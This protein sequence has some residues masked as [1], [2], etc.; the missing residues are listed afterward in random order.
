MEASEQRLSL[1]ENNRLAQ[2]RVERLFSQTVVSQG[3][4][5]LLAIIVAASF[6]DDTAPVVVAGWLLVMSFTVMLR[7]G[8]AYRY[9]HGGLGFRSAAWWEQAHAWS[10]LASGVA[11]GAAGV[12][13]FNH[14][15][16]THQVML[17]VI[18]GG[19]SS[20]AVPLMAVSLR[21]VAS[22]VVPAI[23]PGAIMLITQGDPDSRGL[24]MAAFVYIGT[25]LA[26]ARNF[27]RAFLQ[28]MYLE[29][30]NERLVREAQGR[31]RA[32]ER[33]Q[34]QILM[35]QEVA[36]SLFH[37]LQPRQALDA[38]NIAY[39]ISSHSVFNGDLLLAATRP[40]GR[41]HFLLGDFT[42]HGLA[43]SLGTLPVIDIFTS[44]TAKGFSICDIAAEINRKLHLQLP[45]NIFFAAC[46]ADLD[47]QG[48]QLSVWNGG[49][50]S[51]Y[52][53][54]AEDGTIKQQLES[55]H[56]PL[57]I[58]PEEAFD[59]RPELVQVKEGDQL[60]MA[61]DGVIEQ[62]NAE[63]EAFGEARLEEV[64]NRVHAIDAL[65][66]AIRDALDEFCQ[67]I[68]QTDDLTY[69]A[70]VLDS[71]AMHQAAREQ[72][73]QRQSGRAGN[74]RLMLELEGRTLRGVDPV[75]LVIHLIQELNH[76]EVDA[77]EFELVVG[78]LYKNAL[79]H[80]VL[81]LD[82]SL[83]D[84][85]EGFLR[86]YDE[87]QNRLESLEEGEVRIEVNHRVLEGG[88]GQ[89][90]LQVCD[91]GKG[92]DHRSLDRKLA[93]NDGVHGRGVALAR[94]LCEDVHFEGD[95]NQV[96]ACYRWRAVGD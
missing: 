76:R 67:G 86:Y 55:R 81:E 5:L 53:L 10:A 39:H 30:S 74:W 22:F 6:S 9:E 83:K 46:L 18:L 54:R 66:E 84:S 79:D 51:V 38:P 63:G 64:L 15:E 31:A 49:L 8:L 92:F 13:F 28:N 87:R 7:M 25:L 56:P 60:F 95:G 96:Y 62:I 34:E 65:K 78:E 40:D 35:E 80:G 90:R 37:A 89:L 43:A 94:E 3:A 17:L 36:L 47:P 2:M 12:V 11:W 21:S 93:S 73:Q 33:A 45:P 72:P 82:S 50:P 19:V 85:P 69:L 58:L 48:G 42:G 14:D 27:Q 61:T 57:G 29:I 4:A 75:P 68:G 59:K 77:G 24:G 88:G 16:P 91:S 52:V 44:M 70:V 41:Q 71:K 32:L 23:V 26:V 20:L 1:E